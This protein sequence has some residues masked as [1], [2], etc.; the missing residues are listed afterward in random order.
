MR[1]ASKVAT[2]AVVLFTLT[3]AVVASLSGSAVA[4]EAP[5]LSRSARGGNLATVGA[6]KFEI[7]F[8]R[9]GVRVFP[10][11]ASG[12]PIDP[13]KLNGVATFY[14]PN[15]PEPWFARP[16]R[17][18]NAG[19]GQASESL[20]LAIDLNTVP[21]KGANV[22]FEIAGLPEPAEPGA[23]FT[24]PFEFVQPRDEYRGQSVATAS[25]GSQ[26]SGFPGS[27]LS[28]WSLISRGVYSPLAAQAYYFPLAGFYSTPAGVVWVPRPGYY[29]AVPTEY[30]PGARYTPPP[31]WRMAHPAPSSS[32][33]GS[34]SM[35]SDLSGIHTEYF[36]HAR[37]LGEPA[38]H[39]QWIRE[40]LRQKYGAGSRP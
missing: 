18:T 34:R 40:Q 12:S 3:N 1:N 13:S 31:D 14:H 16:L 11:N 4:Q 22:A 21:P 32:P 2:W 9:T 15:S 6:Y 24:V 7:F 17:P 28:G 35:T 5:K 8:Y 27:S 29:H 37:P 39:E 38:A 10:Q 25:D 23:K 36:W 20:D 33:T 19:R 30:H 26:T